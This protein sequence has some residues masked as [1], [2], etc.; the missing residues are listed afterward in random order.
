MFKKN[1]I[2]FELTILGCSSATPTS[3]RN[4]S[5]QVL[6][7]ADRFFLIDCGEGTQIQLR[8]YKVKFQKINHLFISHLHG[9]HYFGLV[10][11]LSSMHL[12]G[13]TKELHLYAPAELKEII[14]IQ[15]KYSY[16]QLHY[17]LVFHPLQKD[18][19][20]LIFEDEKLTVE[21]IVLNHRINCWGFLFRE[22]PH[23]RNI[24]VEKIKEYKIQ[25]VDIPG[26]KNGG[27]FITEDGRKISNAELTTAGHDQRSYAYCSDTCY[28]EDII[29]KIK[30]VDLLYHEATFMQDKEVRA[31]ETFHTTTIQA[32]TIAK[33]ANVKQLIIG[34]FSARYKDAG[35]LLKETQTVFENTALAEEGKKYVV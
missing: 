33:K 24:L 17:D 22:K 28:D 3:Q 13:R 4:P 21:T 34:H 26:I 32:G 6:N 10:G 19:S 31:K 7:I 23:Q 15:H 5:A 27:D 9:D 29:K 8:R 12:L 1:P 14:D 20:E 18:K 11:L 16:T 2:P 25:A 30:E 35:P